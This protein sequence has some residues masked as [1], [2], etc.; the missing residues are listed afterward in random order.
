MTAKN[1]P[2]LGLPSW[3]SGEESTCQC[4]GH[5][6]NHWSGKIPQAVE[7]L[8]PWATTTKAH[9]LYR[10]PALQQ[11]KPLKQET[12]ALQRRVALLGTPR[13]KP[14][15]SNEDP[16]QPKKKK[17]LGWVEETLDHS[18]RPAS[19]SVQPWALLSR[20]LGPLLGSW[21]GDFPNYSDSM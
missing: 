16:V 7:Q 10:A 9:A 1:D 18:F 8:S 6:F 12:H 20:T 21:Q 2:Q 17:T 14:M 5:G 4:R 19:L 15:H 11:E 3:R 13:E